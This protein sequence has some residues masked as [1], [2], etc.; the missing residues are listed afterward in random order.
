MLRRCVTAAV[1]S[2]AVSAPPHPHAIVI[3]LD[4]WGYAN[5]GA[6]R[7]DPVGKREVVTPNL[8]ALVAEGRELTCVGE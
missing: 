4:D 2:L 1:L 3:L 6:H 7:T 8:D 5:L